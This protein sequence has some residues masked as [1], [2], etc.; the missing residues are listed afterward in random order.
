MQ[1][2]YEKVLNGMRRPILL[3]AVAIVA[4]LSASG[5]A[6]G[7]TS[8]EGR[9]EGHAVKGAASDGLTT[10]AASSDV[11]AAAKRKNFT[12]SSTVPQSG[13]TASSPSNAAGARITAA[14]NPYSFSNTRTIASLKQVTIRATIFDGGTGPGSGDEN[15]LFLELD[16]INTGIALNGFRTGKTDTRT[17]SGSPNQKRAL[18]D[19]LK[20]DGKLVARIFDADPTDVNSLGIP[21]T[22]E[23]TLR[24]K[25]TLTR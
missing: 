20:A 17:I 14:N 4:L 8:T 11:S 16:G 5:V 23:T 2:Y 9:N 10:R 3:V 7:V 12:K 25:G 24:I 18:K 15:D 21:D 1:T 13:V 19:A 22:D 6:M